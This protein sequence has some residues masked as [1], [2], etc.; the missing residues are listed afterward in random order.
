MRKTMN[1]RGA[2]SMIAMLYLVLFSSL[3]VGFVAATSTAVQVA[4]NDDAAQRAILAAESGMEFV[5]FNLSQLNVDKKTP[6]SEI[7]GIVYM[8]L[9][10]MLNGSPN[11]G[12]GS[13]SFVNG[14]IHIPAEPTQF[15]RVNDESGMGR[16]RAAI[17]LKPDALVPELRVRVAGF[18]KDFVSNARGIQ[19]DYHIEQKP[20]QLLDFGV[21]SKGPII[22]KSNAKI[23]GINAAEAGMGSMLTT[24]TQNPAVTMAGSAA[25][26]G[27]VVI[28][29]PTGRFSYS[30][31]SSVGGH[32]ASSPEGQ[33]NVMIGVDAPKF[34]YVDTSVFEPYATRVLSTKG[35]TYGGTLK[36]IRIKADTNPTFDGGSI[37]EGVIYVETPNKITFLSNMT[38]RGVLAV[39]NDPTGDLTTNTLEFRS[40][41]TINGVEALPDLPEWESLKLLGGCAILAP[42]FAVTINSNFGSVG[43]M[44]VGGQITLDSNASG[45]VRG[46]FMTLEN[47]A[48]LMFSS[49]SK[50]IVRTPAK[51][52]APAGLYFD[53]A[54]YP[55]PSTYDE[56]RP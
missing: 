17:E 10:D 12:G 19:M 37:V 40:N 25:V 1:R 32:P 2:A 13:I 49:N 27:K 26:S 30:S 39:Q 8:Q 6:E 4:Y 7:L 50:I 23:S 38:M 20:G 53:S 44:I 45:E 28:T 52:S 5:R 41:A 18:H 43:G 55:T 24:T 21:A 15:V 42:K 11:L 54:Y 46:G 3:A 34:P 33:A 31:N 16:F 14:T 22:L 47:N 56:Y 29:E 9:S 36:N 35:A 48:P 51:D